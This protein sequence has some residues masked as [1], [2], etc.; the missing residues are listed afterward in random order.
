MALFPP[1][2]FGCCLDTLASGTPSDG[3]FLPRPAPA[4]ATTTTSFS[5]APAGL[6]ATLADLGGRPRRLGTVAPGVAVGAVF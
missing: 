1:S 6:A 2:S 4:T 5:T 3:L